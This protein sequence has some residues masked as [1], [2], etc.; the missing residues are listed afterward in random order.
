MTYEQTISYLFSKLPMFQRIGAAAYK[1][2]LENI[3][4]FCE[5]LGNPHQ[6]LA[7]IHVAGTNGKGSTCH[8]L[9]SIFQEAGYK[10]GLFTSPH[11]KNFT[12]RIR[13]NGEEISQEFVIDFTEKTK[14]LIE[15]QQPSFFE[16]TTA[17]AFDYFVSQK[18]DIN[19]IEV[20]MGGRLDST[21]IIT[22]ILS[23]IT[24]I[25][26]DHQ[27][28]LGDTLVEIGGEKAGIIKKN[29][30]VVISD[31]QPEIENVFIDKAKKENAPIFF[32]FFDENAEK[33]KHF[34]ELFVLK[35]I[36][37]KKNLKGVLKAIEILAEKY[38]ITE[39]NIKLG[40]QNV[41]KN[42]H[43]KGRW[44]I[45]ENNPLIICDTAHNEDGVKLVIEQLQDYKNKDKNAEINI[46]FIIGFVKDKNIDKILSLYP[47]NEK[48]YFCGFDSPRSLENISLK[49]QAEKYLLVG[50]MYENVNMA[51]KQAKQKTNKND[52]IFVGGSNFLVAEIDNL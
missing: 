3:L 5:K 29:I 31:H 42:T 22:P 21:N 10:V 43:L 16:V 25:G 34:L 27:Q 46:H 17:M 8:T 13:I 33:F 49:Q 20:G 45:L 35:G 37:Q 19:I 7:C 18:T 47:K 40:L 48:Y 26:Y 38:Q 12:E 1:E 28:F 41:V 39:E 32:S 15:T 9:A 4:L 6:K 52:I 24:T 51:I 14:N 2:G 30:P 44:Q 11:L 23:I 50:E 36:Y